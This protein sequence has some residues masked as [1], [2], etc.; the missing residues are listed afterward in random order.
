MGQRV[1]PEPVKDVAENANSTYT[2]ESNDMDEDQPTVIRLK[3][4]READREDMVVLGY[5]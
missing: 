2:S 1:K 4:Q 5:N 3:S